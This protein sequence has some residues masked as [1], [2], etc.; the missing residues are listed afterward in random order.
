MG[1]WEGE[2][3]GDTRALLVDDEEAVIDHVGGIWRDGVY[4]ISVREDA[5]EILERHSQ[6]S[7]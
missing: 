4:V 1:G 3:E 2:E 6:K 5:P 7:V